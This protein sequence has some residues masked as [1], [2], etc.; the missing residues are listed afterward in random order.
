MDA[1]PGVIDNT[2][3]VAVSPP[4]FAHQSLGCAFP[5]RCFAGA[6]VRRIVGPL[7]AS[8]S[9]FRLSL[10]ITSHVQPAFMR[11]SRSGV[12]ERCP[13]WA[14]APQGSLWAKGRLQ[15]KDAQ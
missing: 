10:S 15:L 9:G 12:E 7:I 2:S 14:G 4:S 1:L 6:V 13:F 5:R 3:S 8:R 11:C